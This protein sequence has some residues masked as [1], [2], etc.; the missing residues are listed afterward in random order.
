[1]VLDLGLNELPLLVRSFGS[2]RSEDILLTLGDRLHLFSG[3]V[4]LGLG[5]AE[6]RLCMFMIGTDD[7]LRDFC[8]LGVLR[9]VAVVCCT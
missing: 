2:L 6:C 5:D 3:G 7:V 1:M 4:P 9:P 8:G